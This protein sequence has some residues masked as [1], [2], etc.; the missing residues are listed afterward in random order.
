MEI[1]LLFT[2]NNCYENSSFQDIRSLGVL[3]QASMV[4][5]NFILREGEYFS[6]ADIPSYHVK[7]PGWLKTKFFLLFFL[8][9]QH[10]NTR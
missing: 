3:Y 2:K 10:G 6:A 4:P 5:V 7:I 9:L 1:C 8:H